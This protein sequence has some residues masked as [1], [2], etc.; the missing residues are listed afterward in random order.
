MNSFI[1]GGTVKFR[2]PPRPPVPKV[3]TIHPLPPAQPSALQNL[4]PDS[5]KVNLTVF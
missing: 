5:V 2:V 3:V 4:S 1:E